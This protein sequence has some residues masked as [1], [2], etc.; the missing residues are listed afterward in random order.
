MPCS[1]SFIRSRL[2]CLSLKAQPLLHNFLPNKLV[3]LPLRGQP[4]LTPHL[5]FNCCSSLHLS[6]CAAS[7]TK[8]SLMSLPQSLLYIVN[9]YHDTLHSA[10]VF[11]YIV[12]ITECGSCL[13]GRNSGC[14]SM[15]TISFC[16]HDAKHTDA[17][18]PYFTI[19]HS[20]GCQ[21]KVIKILFTFRIAFSSVAFVLLERGRTSMERLL[22]QL[23]PNFLFSPQIGG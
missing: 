16:P 17:F 10:S 22:W 3:S 7:S 1:L 19:F 12:S 4:L 2:F 9:S 13:L 14:L 6:S 18:F 8:T 5:T 15:K 20:L 21:F 23:H 11:S